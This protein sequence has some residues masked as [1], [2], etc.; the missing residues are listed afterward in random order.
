MHRSIR[1]AVEHPERQVRLFTINRSLAELLKSTINAVHGSLPENLY[2]A[3]VY[4]FLIGVIGLFENPDRFRLV[5]DR[6][7]ERIVDSWRDFFYHRAK[8][9]DLNIFSDP[10]MK[11]LLRMIRSRGQGNLDASRYCWEEMVFLQ[12]GYRVS[13]RQRYLSR[14]AEP[15][16][17]RSIGLNQQQRGLFLRV[18][19]RW[20]EWLEHGDLCN[21]DGITLRAAEYFEEAESLCTIRE[22]FPTDFILADEA[23]D[24]STMELRLLRRLL[25]DP[26][27]EN[28]M[29]LG[30]DLNQKVYPKHWRAKAAGYNF[31]GRIDV[32]RR[33]YRNTR[34]ILKA[35]C[36][37]PERYPPPPEEHIPV[38]QPELS[39]HE[40]SQPIAIE[41][42]HANH[43]EKVMAVAKQVLSRER[44]QRV[45]VVSGNDILLAEVRDRASRSGIECFELFTIEDIDLWRAQAAD[46]LSAHSSSRNWR[47]SKAS[48]STP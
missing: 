10:A 46:P 24:F 41:C 16:L 15:R 42:T 18:L 2:V 32:I 23:Q 13:E 5:D 38:M 21:V 28:A 11:N 36:L 34:Q 45:V 39:D 17:G 35:A 33:N 26:D 8:R 6:S 12:S 25:A 30:G 44:G 27:A 9:P 19:D 1:L 7:N 43:L 47:Q 20:E 14:L 37:L 48:S 22:R 29:F 3:A 40:G 4:D 31:Q